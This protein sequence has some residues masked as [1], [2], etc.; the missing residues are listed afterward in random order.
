M[1]SNSKNSNR[2]KDSDLCK[3]LLYPASVAL[4]GASDDTKKTGGRPQQFLRRAGFAGK[5]Y[6]INPNRAEV[7]GE[8]AWPSLAALPEVPDT[9]FVLSPTDT[10]VDTVRE[11][12]RLGVKLVVILAS[13]FSETGPEG[14]AREEALR[15]IA[16]DTG[17]RLLG[18]SSLGVVN[19]SNGLM[20][21]ANAAFAEPDMPTGNVFV[22]SHSGSMIGALVSRGK[23]RGVG[24]AGLVS[25]GSEVDLSVGEICMATLDDPKIE[26]YVLF[27]ESLHHGD[28]LKAFAREAALRG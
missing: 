24:F 6:P 17:I 19:P 9:V 15:Q 21:T 13:G 10:V 7:Q 25:V 1:S 3:A 12:A 18:P 4:V 16:E 26:G 28:K 8:Q 14:A 5:V 2:S 22:A 20:L 27:L 23:A 11:C